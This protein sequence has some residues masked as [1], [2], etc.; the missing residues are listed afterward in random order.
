MISYTVKKAHKDDTNFD[1]IEKTGISHEFT[2]QDILEEEERFEKMV[3]EIEAN[4]ELKEAVKT[5]VLSNNEWLKDMEEEKIHACHLYWEA[6]AYV[7][8]GKLKVK[9]IKGV[10]KS[11]EK[12]RKEI[13]AQA[14]GK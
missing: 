11:S 5:N 1:V 2:V 14:Y 13:K 9:E 4:M 12:E 3:K 6:H 7:K 8:G 10:L